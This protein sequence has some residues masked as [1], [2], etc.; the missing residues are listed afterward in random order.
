VVVELAG[1]S[2]LTKATIR[3]PAKLVLNAGVDTV[4]TPS[5]ATVRS[6]AMGGVGEGVTALDGADDALLPMLFEATTVN[7]YVVPFV[8]PFT[9]VDVE[10]GVPVT[11]VGVCAVA[12]MKGVTVYDV[13]APPAVGALQLTAASPLPAVAVTFVGAPGAGGGVGTTVFDGADGL[14]L[15]VA[16]A[17]VTV[18]V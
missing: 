2:A 12:P 10:G 18:N 7:V 5:A 3:S 9:T 13:G 8:S 15:P 17:A 6:T 14:L 16:L 11:V 4:P 1:P